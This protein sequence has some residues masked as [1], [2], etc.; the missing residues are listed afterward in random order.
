MLQDVPCGLPS[1]SQKTKEGC[2]DEAAKN[3]YCRGVFG[4][5]IALAAGATGIITVTPAN[6]IQIAVRWLHMTAT[7]GVAVSPVAFTQGFA[8]TAIQILGDNMMA[9]AGPAIGSTWAAEQTDLRE[10]WNKY[11]TPQTPVTITVVNLD[12]VLP[13]VAFA[14]IRGDFIK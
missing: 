2:E 9:N 5:S 7:S 1:P 6:T 12:P 8:V 3:K 14:S 10:F 11:A 4:G 13:I